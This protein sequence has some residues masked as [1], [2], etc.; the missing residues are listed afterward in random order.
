MAD[1]LMYRHTNALGKTTVVEGC[2]NGSPPNCELMD[3]GVDFRGQQSGSDSRLYEFQG[4]QGQAAGIAYALD[5]RRLL[6]PDPVAFKVLLFHVLRALPGIGVYVAGMILSLAYGQDVPALDANGLR[7]LA[8]LYGVQEA[9]SRSMVRRQLQETARR[10]LPEGRAG[11][12]NEALIEFGALVCTPRD[13]VCEDCPIVRSC[14]AVALG[15]QHSIPVRLPRRA[16][17]H[18]DVTAAVIWSGGRVLISQRLND[19]MLGGLWEFPGGKCETAESYDACL[20]REIREELALDIEVAEPLVTFDH[21]YS[22]LHIT[23]HVFHCRPLSDP[24]RA[25]EVAD[26][27]WVALDN[28]GDFP[29]S[30][31]DRRIA[32]ALIERATDPGACP[33]G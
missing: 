11:E 31:A 27:R 13:P 20:R 30:V 23:L 4:F 26:W 33:V 5:I 16:I 18:R 7:V 10:V 29:L 28:L 22:H 12:F 19:R 14:R 25:I 24:P 8:R 1:H 9:V 3:Q 32:Q 6:D 15:L 2:G 17:P 21:A